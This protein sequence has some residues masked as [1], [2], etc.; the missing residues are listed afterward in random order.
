MREHRFS[1]AHPAGHRGQHQHAAHVARPPSAAPWQ[2]PP[3]LAPVVRTSSIRERPRP[4]GGAAR[5]DPAHPVRQVRR[6]AAGVQSDRV[7][8]RPGRHQAG[9][10]ARRTAA[11][12]PAH[13]G[14]RPGHRRRP[15]RHPCVARGRP[16][17]GRGHQP[18]RV[19]SRPSVRSRTT[20]GRARHRATG[21]QVPPAALLAGQDRRS[22]GIGVPGQRPHRRQHRCRWIRDG[23]GCCSG[24]MTCRGRPAD[25][26]VA[27]IAPWVRSAAP[28]AGR[29][30]TRSI[31]A[32][33]HSRSTSGGARPLRL[34]WPNHRQ[35]PT[36][37]ARNRSANVDNVQTGNGPGR[38]LTGR[39]PPSMPPDRGSRAT[40]RR[41]AGCRAGSGQQRP[42][43]GL[44]W[45]GTPIRRCVTR[46]ARRRVPLRPILRTTSRA[47]R[48]APPSPGSRRRCVPASGTPTPAGPR[49]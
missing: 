1:A 47:D 7:P 45:L 20:P 29:G 6:P 41:S 23:S 34:P 24:T 46:G 48:A 8:G 40:I 32:A 39:P 21:G 36:G 27:P 26:R 28:R 31:A 14:R 5:R 12:R 4:A 37:P 22:D 38:S 13:S 42:A 43:V 44:G 33:K 16:P 9:R 3:M 2:A 17:A 19:G 10:D 49:S 18:D 25:R 11:A 30:S 35:G 15:G